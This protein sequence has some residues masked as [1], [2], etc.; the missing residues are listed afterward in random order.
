MMP[1]AFLRRSVNNSSNTIGP[2]EVSIVPDK[3]RAGKNALRRAT[4]AK[5]HF[6]KPL[7][8]VLAHLEALQLWDHS[9]ADQNDF[10][11][12]LCELFP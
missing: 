11:F 2:A 8:A 9:A 12:C 7:S 1:A 3:L 4:R 10:F 5:F 6:L